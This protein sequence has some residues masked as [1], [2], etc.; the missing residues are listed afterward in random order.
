MHVPS[1]PQ[2]SAG[3][4]GVS[5]LLQVQPAATTRTIGANEN[6]LTSEY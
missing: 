1:Q 2:P 6:H 3:Q 5:Q 4:R